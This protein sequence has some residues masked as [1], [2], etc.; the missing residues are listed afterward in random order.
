MKSSSPNVVKS[1][2]EQVR[3]QLRWLGVGLFVTCLLLVLIFALRATAFTTNI[4][5]QLEAESLLRQVREHP[6]LPLPRGNALSAY[7]HWNEIPENLS[8]HFGNARTISG[9]AIEAKVQGSD[10]IAKYF[11]LMRYANEK[12]DEIFLLSQHDETEVYTVI[13]AFFRTALAQAF[14]LTS[15]IFILLFFLVR[16]LLRRT[17]EPMALL[18]EWASS[19]GTHPERPLD[20]KFPIEEL[21]QLALQLRGGI[22]QVQAHN[23][24]EKQF[25][26]HASHELRTPLA[27]V[28][29]SLDTL[30]LRAD[31]SSQPTVQRALKATANMRQLSATLLWLARESERP[32]GKSRVDAR[33][34]CK[35]I[36]DD[37]RYL[38]DKRSID[39]KSEIRVNSLE[40]ERDLLAIIIANLVRNAFF[41]STEGSIRFELS[42]TG[43]M[44]TNPVNGECSG[45]SNSEPGGYGLGL[46]LVQRICTKMAWEFNFERTSA[47]V[48]ASVRWR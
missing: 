7:R 38:L 6:A 9:V 5:M 26:Q 21:N 43:L 32:I 22:E 29:A 45:E 11:Y 33:A 28:Q 1:L 12:G 39:V 2:A 47:H 36:I 25:L 31:Q 19:L 10:G 20:V 24:R 44:I 8:R 41:Y 15:I 40:I 13:N 37:H 46:Q 42:A 23:Q 27:I 48:L 30:N 18:S 3:W 16:W 14:W 17:T 4:L 35:Q 34:L